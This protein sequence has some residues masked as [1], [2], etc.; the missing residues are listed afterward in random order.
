MYKCILIE[1]VSGA[2]VSSFPST[3]LEVPGTGSQVRFRG[4]CASSFEQRHTLG[5]AAGKV[6]PDVVAVPLLAC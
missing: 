4:G 6:L 3:H 2:V 5:R 1:T